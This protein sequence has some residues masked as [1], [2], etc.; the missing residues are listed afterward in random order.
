[1]FCVLGKQRTGMVIESKYVLFTMWISNDE[2]MMEATLSTAFGTGLFFYF[3]G[4]KWHSF[5]NKMDDC[6][7]QSAQLLESLIH[8]V[9]WTT[10]LS[11]FFPVFFVCP[12][13]GIFRGYSQYV[14]IAMLNYF[15]YRFC[16]LCKRWTTKTKGKQKRDK[17]IGICH[18]FV[19]LFV[20]C[21]LEIDRL[22]PTSSPRYSFFLQIRIYGGSSPLSRA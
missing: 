8:F 11:C 2:W 21:G 17:I 20:W 1:M 22:D 13:N 6:D 5:D 14:D 4:S 18:C 3:A 19:I 7:A 12:S 16:F 9:Q 10:C 15:S